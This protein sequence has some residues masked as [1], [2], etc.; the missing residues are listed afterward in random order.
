MATRE[1]YSVSCK[2]IDDQI[3]R[4]KL[5]KARQGCGL[6]GQLVVNGEVMP[7]YVYMGR[8]G[9]SAHYCPEYYES[10]GKS[11]RKVSGYGDTR[12]YEF[13]RKGVPGIDTRTIPNEAI[14]AWAFGSPIPDLE[15]EESEGKIV[16]MIG[17]SSTGDELADHIIREQTKKY[18]A[19]NTKKITLEDYFQLAEEWGAAVYN[20]D[21]ITPCRK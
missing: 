8:G 3:E 12:F 15:A 5:F 4:L 13:I 7:A 2:D 16:E 9:Y 14:A 18:P 11:T 1:G 20:E 10:G 19:W 6:F 21:N 17:P